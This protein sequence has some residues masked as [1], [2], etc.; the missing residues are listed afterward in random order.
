MLGHLKH[1]K[2]IIEQHIGQGIVCPIVQD[3][4]GFLAVTRVPQPTLNDLLRLDSVFSE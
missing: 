1:R 4:F 3:F 2:E